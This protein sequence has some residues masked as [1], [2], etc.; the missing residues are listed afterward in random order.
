FFYQIT[1]R[2]KGSSQKNPAVDRRLKPPCGRKAACQYEKQ[3][4]RHTTAGAGKSRQTQ[5][6]AETVKKKMCH[7]PVSKDGSG[8]RTQP[9]Q[10]AGQQ[11]QTGDRP[12][13]GLLLFLRLLPSAISVSQF[14]GIQRRPQGFLRS[15]FFS[16]HYRAQALP[17]LPSTSLI[18]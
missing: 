10:I 8:S 5:H 13:T 14:P 1:A 4:P 2:S 6:G 15:F 11:T 18:L 12:G 16:V 17:S 7:N 9:P 3:R